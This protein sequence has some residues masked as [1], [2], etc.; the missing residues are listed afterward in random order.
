V[1]MA[2]GVVVPFIGPERWGRGRP[3]SDGGGGVLSKWW[4]IMEGG[5]GGWRRVMRG[6]EGDEMPVRFS[7]SRAEESDR[8]WRTTR[9][10]RPKEAFAQA[11]G[12]GRCPRAGPK[13]HDWASWDAGLKGFFRQK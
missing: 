2:A 1:K 3:G 13:G 5:R 10:C 9:W 7:Y 4:P 8:R 12:G 6:N 11:S